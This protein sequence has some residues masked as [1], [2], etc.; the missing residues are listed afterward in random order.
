MK[1]VKFIAAAFLACLLCSCGG[2]EPNDIAFVVALGFDKGTQS[3]YEITIQFAKVNQIS[4]GSSENGGKAGPEIIQNVTVEAP[5]MYSAINTANH[6][7]SKKF[8][9]SHAKLIVFSRSLAEE[10]IGSV[11]DTIIRS[12]EIKPD[13]YMA[14]AK[15]SAKEYLSEVKPVVEVNPAK[16]YQLVYGE[17]ESGGIPKTNL[18]NFYFDK[19]AEKKSSVVPLA[20]V[21]QAQS[22]G[23]DGTE[24]ST[25]NNA[26]QNAPV[27]EEGFEY[28]VKNYTA[29]EVAVNGENKSE[30]MGMAVF[31]GDKMIGTLGSVDGELYNLLSGTLKRSY[32]SFRNRDNDTPVI[33]KIFQ[34]KKPDYNI[35]IENK[36]IDI[37]LFLES[38]LY[39]RPQENYDVDRLEED[40]TNDINSSAENF[41][42]KVRDEM[43]CDILGIEKKLGYKFLT[44]ESLAEYDF[45]S[46]F[47][48]YEIRVDAKFEIRRIG[49]KT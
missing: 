49:M 11:V 40:I 1:A 32:I 47:K 42:K 25:E 33:V 26:N 23:E 24:K 14:V 4:G 19:E 27:N 15:D 10:G 39:S 22:G 6:I 34:Y 28:K 20:G 36:T 17:N 5:D 21:T 7:V 43:G 16:Y 9:L 13:V 31:S 38:D 37:K 8:S 35:D 18:L 41:I 3:E 48:N 46:D 30:A 12:N 45:K 44:N 29:G 2:S